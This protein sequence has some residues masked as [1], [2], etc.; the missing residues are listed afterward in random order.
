M[1][2]VGQR[3][4]LVGEV[5]D[6]A[7]VDAGV[8]QRG[9]HTIEG[10][11]HFDLHHVRSQ[12]VTG[13]VGK[14]E[15]GAK[16]DDVV[17]GAHAGIVGIEQVDEGW[18][19]RSGAVDGQRARQA[20]ACAAVACTVG[21]PGRDGIRTGIAGG[22]QC[23][24]GHVHITGGDVGR[25][26]D[27]LCNDIGAAVQVV[28]GDFHLVPGQSV[29]RQGHPE[30][31][32][33]VG[34]GVIVGAQACVIACVVGNGGEC[35]GQVG[36]DG[37]VQFE[38][39]RAGR[40]GA[41]AGRIGGDGAQVV[42][43]IRQ[44]HQIVGVGATAV[45]DGG[46]DRRHRVLRIQRHGGLAGVLNAIVVE[47]VEDHQIGTCRACSAQCDVVRVPGEPHCAIDVAHVGIGHPNRGGTASAGVDGDHQVCRCGIEG[48][49]VAGG[50][51]GLG[52]D[53]VFAIGQ[54]CAAGGEYETTIAR[55]HVG[56]AQQDRG[57]EVR[58]SGRVVFGIQLDVFRIRCGGATDC[59]V[60]G[61]GGDVVRRGAAP[62]FI[63]RQIQRGHGGGCGAVDAQQR[64][65]CQ[66]AWAAA[67][68]R[69]VAVKVGGCACRQATGADQGVTIGDV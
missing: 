53:T 29:A 37:A 43:P 49:F 67:P 41:V 31:G 69:G 22:W 57:T 40:G 33:G 19:A 25:R 47:V 50:I 58:A 13:V 66:G 60:R 9:R 64:Q 54:G 16:A 23:A 11:H 46:T 30:S 27:A 63:E 1:R 4:A 3:R 26:Q 62:I 55:H 7:G 12:R 44:V 14:A 36:A 18:C 56:F 51:E 34:G 35:D 20:H 61:F 45:D 10:I 65:G 15:V 5:P 38:A 24:A 17:A 48:T 59:D 68:S 39:D 32:C 52:T 21:V 6:P 42:D 28:L 2:A 8:T